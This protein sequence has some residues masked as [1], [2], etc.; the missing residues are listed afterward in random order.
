MY[1]DTGH[2]VMYMDTG[3]YVMYMDTGHYVMYMDTGH[4]VTYMDTG[5]YVINIREWTVLV[6]LVDTK[7]EYSAYFR[8]VCSYI[9]IQTRCH[10]LQN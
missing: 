4:Y 10:N 6:R 3:H 7:C 9:T 5:H 8:N 1:M 2:Y